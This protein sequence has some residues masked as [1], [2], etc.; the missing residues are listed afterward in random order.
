M[1]NEGDSV[2]SQA[3]F[4]DNHPI[5]F[6]NLVWYFHRLELPHNLLRLVLTSQHVKPQPQDLPL[7]MF[8]S[9]TL[10]RVRILWDVLTLDP[11]QCPPLYVL[12]RMYSQL[13]MQQWRMVNQ[14]FTLA[15]LEEVVRYVG[16]NEVHKAI[17]LIVET[18]GRQAVQ[19][20]LQ[21]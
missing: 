8:H 16:L 9:N 12:W 20:P 15:Y 2:L 10:L 14:P 18:L 13:P 21:R 3:E 1:E 19:P 11:D 7:W 17:G 6:W 4:V 5:I